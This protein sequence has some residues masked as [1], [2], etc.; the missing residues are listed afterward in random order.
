M[1]QKLSCI[2]ERTE[3]VEEKLSSIDERIEKIKNVEEKLS[4]VDERMDKIHTL[5]KNMS[6]G[7]KTNIPECKKYKFSFKYIKISLKFGESTSFS[8]RIEKRT[9]FVLSYKT[10]PINIKTLPKPFVPSPVR[11]FTGRE[12]EI[13]EI[14]N[15]ITGQSTRLLNIWGSPGFGKTSTAI[16]AA[17]RLLSLGLPVYFFKFERIRTV[18]EFLSKILSIFKSNLADRSLKPTDKLVSILR[19]ISSRIF[20]IFDNLDD[21]LS[22]ESSSVRLESLFGQLLDS[23]VNVNVVFTTRELLEN[24]NDLIE[25]FRDIRIRPLHP[26]S[27]V[28]FVR[29]LLPSFSESVVANVAKISSNVPLAMKLVASIV[30]NNNEDMANKI[31]EELSLS[32][33]LLEID[34]PYKQ[35]M[36]RV[37]ETPFEQLPLVDKHA[38]ISL[39]VFSSGRIIKDAAVHVISDEIGFLKPLGSLNT[40]VKKSLI[41]VDPCGEYYTIHPLIHSFVVDKA[42]EIDFVHVVLSSIIRFSRYFFRRFE[43]INDDFLCG[44]P[45][46]IAKLQDEMEHLSIAIHYFTTSTCSLENCQ[47]LFRIFSK[48][49]IFLFLIG[50]P[51]VALL[52]ISKLYDDA[53]EKCRTQQYNY[54]YSK[55]YVSKYF[56]N[57][58]FS[59][60]FFLEVEYLEIPEHIHEDVLLLSDGSAA[61]LGCYEGITIISRRNI[62]AGIECI[63][64]HV[65][66]LQNCADQQLIKCLCLQLLALFD[67]DLKE[68][69]KSNNLSKEAIEVCKEIGNYNLFLIGDCDETLSMTQREEHKGEQLIVFVYLLCMW[70][71]L[72]NLGNE[73]QHYF[74][75]LVRQL[76]QQLENKAFN[77][78]QYLFQIFTYGDVILACLGFGAGQEVLLDEKITFLEKSVMSGDCCSRTDRT[79]PIRAEM[80]SMFCSERLLNCYV[81]QMIRDD[82]KIIQGSSVLDTCRSALDHSLKQCGE[83]HQNTAFC[84]FRMGLAE[85]NLGNYISACNAFH[86]ALEILTATNVGNSSSNAVLAEVYIGKGE[87]YQWLDKF[88]SAIACFEEGLKIKRKL[89]SEDTEEIAQILVLLGK[90][91][92][93]SNDLSSALATLENALQIRKKLY[94]EK[95]SSNGYLNVVECYYLIGQLLNALG[96]NTESIKCFKTALEVSADCDQER[97]YMQSHIFVELINLKADESVYM[98]LLESSLLVIKE[99]YKSFLP[100]L[101]LRLGS[102]QITPGK[103]KAGLALFQDALGIEL[104]ITLR[105]NLFIR[106][107]TVSCYIAMVE[108]LNKIGKLNLARK[109]IDRATQVAES[110]PE[111]TR[112]RWIF[113]CY[114]WKGHVQNLMREYSAALESLKH[115]YLQISKL[116]DESCDK[117]EQVWCHMKIAAAHSFVGSYKD[118]LTSLYEALSVVKGSSSE[119][120]TAEAAVYFAVAKVS[121]KMK[122]K[123]LEVYNLRLAYKMCSKV[124]GETHSKTEEIYI[125]YARALIR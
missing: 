87:A 34:G 32:G 117:L 106:W 86:Q 78:S 73:T 113:R 5:M 102:K 67:T 118:S 18:D 45:V 72:I 24:M 100:I 71:T 66:G 115:A 104:E 108:A 30:E 54:P 57:I 17:R 55:L 9:K 99:N 12:D 111:G 116:S 92:L 98:E 13:E 48:S 8:T 79:F 33:N 36:K 81:L 15:L 46:D 124:L 50:L 37:F 68:C 52:D 31:L 53:I 16:E 97:S 11:L 21:L 121:K 49:E 28:E 62:K 58:A 10:F 74:L 43:E 119:G 19:E 84:Y 60:L 38:L 109:A 41:D 40:L 26:V 44:K 82:R 122:N 4:F 70:S 61:K 91:Q 14:K 75:K 3:N 96:N 29:K 65:N 105:S 110:L 2:D 101:Y 59:S 95:R 93:F 80:S 120:S 39:T 88:V 35:N 63:E 1:E 23:N 123:T 85:N 56:Q 77:A 107:T 94:A 6:F 64:K 51:P 69:S 42:K 7:E 20:L 83:Q 27:S 76:E 103:D 125:A 89:C 47:D 114:T 25:F 22:S 90:S 112:Y